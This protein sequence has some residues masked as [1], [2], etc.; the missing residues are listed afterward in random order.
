MNRRTPAELEAWRRLLRDAGRPLIDLVSS[1]LPRDGHPTPAQLTAWRKAAGDPDMASA[2]VELVRARRASAWKFRDAGPGAPTPGAPAELCPP[3]QDS[4]RPPLCPITNLALDVHGG[5][6]ATPW[7]IAHHKAQRIVDRLGSGTPVID[8]CC[9]VG[10]DARE[11]VIAGLDVR[12]VDLDP[13]RVWMCRHNT[14]C[15]TQVADAAEL[16]TSGFTLH[17]DPARRTES[18]S[19]GRAR[20]RSLNDLLPPIDTIAA[21]AAAARGALVKLGP[22]VNPDELPALHAPTS[23]EYISLDGQLSQAVWWIGPL[24]DDPPVRA[25]LVN[26]ARAAVF[27]L[28]GDPAADEQPSESPLGA[29]VFAVDPAIERAGLLPTLA[30]QTGLAIVHPALGLLTDDPHELGGGGVRGWLEHA[31]LTPFIVRHEMPWRRERVAQWLADHDAGL[32]EVKTRAKACDPDV[33][34]R[35]LRAPGHTPYCVFVLRFGDAIRAI[36]T[37]RPGPP[38]S[39]AA[40]PT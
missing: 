14:D 34:Q 15:P 16:D 40:T 11:F 5:E 32:V 30:H 24:A 19:G 1:S 10:A 2:A 9:G 3:G 25:T 29:H 17:I 37:E 6:Q 27:T 8:A 26:S 22:G 21:L 13:V 28:A 7:P 23:L 31:A 36:I 38:R 18:R 35:E 20:I 12:V 4:P 39:G 33:E